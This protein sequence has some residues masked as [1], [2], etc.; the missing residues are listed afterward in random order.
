MRY[1]FSLLLAVASF[2]AVEA[3]TIPQPLQVVRVYNVTS[4]AQVI[5]NRSTAAMGCNYFSYYVNSSAGAYTIQ[6]E[7]SDVSSGGPWTPFPTSQITN[8]SFVPI[9]VGNGF[10]NWV[11]LNTLVGSTSSTFSCSKDYFITSSASTI[12]AVADPGQD[13]IP[14]RSGQG[15]SRCAVEGDLPNTVLASGDTTGVTDQA[16]IQRV[17][18]SLPPTGGVVWLDNINGPFYL[19]TSTGISIGNGSTSA[20]SSVNGIRLACVSAGGAWNGAA[21]MEGG[22]CVINSNVNGPAFYIHGP[23]AGWEIDDIY[24]NVLSTNSAARALRIESAQWGNVNRFGCAINTTSTNQGCIEDVTNAQTTGGFP[25]GLSNSM[26]NK[27]TD[28]NVFLGANATSAFGIHLQSG[29]LGISDPCFEQYKNITS[30]AL[31]ADQVHIWIASA[32]SDE[33]DLV[34]TMNLGTGVLFDYTSSAPAYPTDVVFFALDMG[35]SNTLQ[36]LGNPP[37]GAALP[38]NMI[39]FLGQ[40]NGARPASL[41]GLNIWSG[42]QLLFDSQFNAAIPVVGFADPTMQIA[43]G[44]VTNN[45]GGIVQNGP[46]TRWSGT[47]S[48]GGFFDSKGGIENVINAIGNPL[49]DWV[50]AT[51]GGSLGN[52]PLIHAWSDGTVS[53]GPNFAKPTTPGQV[54]IQNSTVGGITELIVN[55]H[56]ATQDLQDWVNNGVVVA[57]VGPNG[58]SGTVIGTGTNVQAYGATGAGYPT[59]DTAAVQA[60][61]NAT[62]ATTGYGGKVFFP[63]PA[64]A[65]YIAGQLTIPNR[66]TYPAT[67]GA[68]QPC[69]LYGTGVTWDWNNPLGQPPGGSRL[70]MRYSGFGGKIYSNGHGT[71]AI[72]D[73]NFTDGNAGQSA[74][75]TPYIYTTNTELNVYNNVAYGDVSGPRALITNAATS[76]GNVLYFASTA[77]ITPGQ[78]VTYTSTPGTDIPYGVFVSSVTGN[79]VTLNAPVSGTVANGS[80]VTFGGTTQDFV[81]FGGLPIQ[82]TLSATTAQGSNILTFASTTDAH[83]N[84]PVSGYLAGYDGL[85]EPVTIL[86]VNSTTITLSGNATTAIPAGTVMQFSPGTVAGPGLIEDDTPFAPFRG[87]GTKAEHNLISQMRGFTLG[88]QANGIILRDNGITYNGGGIAAINIEGGGTYFPTSGA[89]NNVI[90]GNNMEGNGYTS[91]IRVDYSNNNT[92]TGNNCV[93]GDSWTQQNY[94]FTIHSSFNHVVLGGLS[95]RNIPEVIDLS[96]NNW[97]TGVHTEQDD[98]LGRLFSY[99]RTLPWGSFAQLPNP[100]NMPFGAKFLCT[101]CAR[102]TPCTSGG[103]VVEATYANSEWECGGT[104]ASIYSGFPT[105]T[106][107][108]QGFC[109]DCA[110]TPQCIQGTGSGAVATGN[111]TQIHFTT[112]GSTSTGGTVL[113]FASTVG[114]MAGMFIT[115]T[116]NITG[117]ERI[118]TMTTTSVTMLSCSPGAGVTGHISSG[119]TI[120]FMIGWSCALP[121]VTSTAANLPNVGFYPYY[122]GQSIYCTDCTTAATCTGGGS[123]HWAVANGSAWTCQ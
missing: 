34:H 99:E 23:I 56:N 18:N 19:P 120:N 50:V 89:Y 107:G 101:G 111:T 84:T 114:L 39:Y 12:S 17:I 33:F 104:F 109:L 25:T 32:D 70:D 45:S 7:Y 29:A 116:N 38:P 35:G 52:T 106:E 83:G 79:S 46:F 65:Y 21:G 9:G 31:R 11:R 63:T 5:D 24:V 53:I 74:D 68:Q 59:D 64:V 88:S 49:S 110:P 75:M 123:G 71:L 66:G 6:L 20:A 73:L 76:S 8:T 117:C 54:L 87:Y 27:F 42:N 119:D 58:F 90:D 105:A 72:H 82:L 51:T 93:D 113:H 77:G 57:S 22:S 118:N 30:Q 122:P 41:P 67:P 61:I 16:N 86:T 4:A 97:A 47:N 91:C 121:P 48:A 94:L 80:S 40:T 81:Q 3:Q 100:A 10:H 36:N 62:C 28:I 37:S 26:H 112:N 2:F 69:E 96:Q 1:I 92:I 98:S 95:N 108:A 102:S 15:M 85:A 14:Y 115:N 44:G 60:A 55:A 13:C 78:S 103:F 43:M